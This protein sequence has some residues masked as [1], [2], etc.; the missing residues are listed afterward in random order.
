MAD[1]FITRYGAAREWK[2]NVFCATSPANMGD[3]LSWWAGFAAV[4]VAL[5]RKYKVTADVVED[6]VSDFDNFI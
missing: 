4:S 1:E 3:H 2:K 6:N 5:H